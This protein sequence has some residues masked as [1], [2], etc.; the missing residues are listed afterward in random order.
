MSGTF[1]TK[2]GLK[3]G[4]TLLPLLSKFALEY[5]VRW[6]KQNGND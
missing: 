6:V 1:P 2:N 4:D 3:Q 5:D